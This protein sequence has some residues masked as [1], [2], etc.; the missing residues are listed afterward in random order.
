MKQIFLFLLLVLLQ[1]ALSAQVKTAG[2]NYSVGAP[3]WTPSVNTG[4][5]LAIDTVSKRIYLWNRN[6]GAWDI[7]GQGIDNTSGGTPPAYTPGQTDSKF[8]INNANPPELY[9]WTGS[10]WAKVSGTVQTIDTFSVSGS[11]VSLSLSGDAQSAKTI[12]L[13][14]SGIT[15]LTGDVIATGPGS[16]AATIAA[17]AV[18][19]TKL[20]TG[21]VD[22]VKVAALGISDVHVKTVAPSKI[23]QAGATAG[24]VL[25]WNG[26]SNIW[27][28]ATVSGGSDW[29]LTGNAATAGSSFLGTTNN[30]SLRFRT[31]NVQRMIVDSLGRVGINGNS[32]AALM[33]ITGTGTASGTFPLQLFNSSAAQLLLVRDD[34]ALR[35][36]SASTGFT[37]FPYATDPNSP[38]T[39]QRNLAISSAVTTQGGPTGLLCLSGVDITATLS[40]TVVM[41]VSKGFAPISG[42]ADYVAYQ[43]R[44]TINQTG[45]SNGPVR[46]FYA[47]PVATAST[48]IRAL[49]YTNNA[50]TGWGIYGVGTADNALAGSIAIGST[51]TPTSRADITGANGYTQLRL[52][53]TYTPTSSADALG[54]VGDTAHDANYFYIKTSA[55]WKRAALSTF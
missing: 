24:Q 4:S 3:A 11:I 6:T 42:S 20:G 28:P 53:T 27:A 40:G 14:A 29:A 47:N 46:M 39:G 33:Q 1:T 2:V 50:G 22:S 12:T 16:V 9:A 35:L 8:A 37:I 51:S 26:T 36:S 49:E 31:N 38:G 17:G 15:A 52:R 21:S 48:N 18:T 25:A 30:T 10:A 55:G 44:P 7:Q 54:N 5:E 19:N 45:G 32:S 13:P 34:G 41:N 43:A 23:L